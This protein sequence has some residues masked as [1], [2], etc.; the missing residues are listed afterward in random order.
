M[1]RLALSSIWTISATVAVNSVSDA[2]KLGCSAP[3]SGSRSF[4]PR[5]SPKPRSRQAATR[6][7]LLQTTHR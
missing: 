7:N 6:V 2:L 4:E 3:S 5:D 1:V